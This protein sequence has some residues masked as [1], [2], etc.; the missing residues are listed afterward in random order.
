M[1][2]KTVLNRVYKV[3]GFVYEKTRFVG[4]GIEVGVR[5]V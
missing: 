4:D 3:K 1:R 5:E 2:V